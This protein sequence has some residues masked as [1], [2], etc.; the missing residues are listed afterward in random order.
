MTILRGGTVPSG[1]TAYSGSEDVLSG[2]LGNENFLRSERWMRP[3]SGETEAEVASAEPVGQELAVHQSE[4]DAEL[5]GRAERRVVHR[6]RR[7]SVGRLFVRLLILRLHVSR[8]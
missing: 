8:Y 1:S 7:R 3:S 2:S 5:T 4:L 6:V